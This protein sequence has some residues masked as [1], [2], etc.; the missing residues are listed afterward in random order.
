MC[1]VDA[2]SSAEAAGA[3]ASRGSMVANRLADKI[4]PR[5]ANAVRSNSRA[6]I[7]RDC[8]VHVGQPSSRA[9]SALVLPSR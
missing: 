6:C 9:A 3:A 8:T 5:R 1:S 4:N 7:S 2:I